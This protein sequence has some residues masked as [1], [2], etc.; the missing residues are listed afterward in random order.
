M[1]QDHLGLGEQLQ[2]QVQGVQVLGSLEQ[3]ALASRFAALG[4][5]PLQELQHLLQLGVDRPLVLLV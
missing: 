4:F 2:Q 3:P 5:L 1:G